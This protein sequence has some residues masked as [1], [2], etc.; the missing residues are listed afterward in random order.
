VSL[1]V[2]VV[3]EDHTL[4]QFVAIPVIAALLV[5]VGKPNAK[6]AAVTNPRVRGFENLIQHACPI[7][8]RYGAI[9]DVV[10]FIVD[11]DCGGKSGG[12]RTKAERLQRKLSSCDVYPDKAIVV[13]AVNEIEVWALWGMRREL[14]RR[15]SDVRAECHPKEIYFDPLLLAGDRFTPD[16]GRKRLISLSLREGWDS[17]KQGCPE[18]SR[19]E[20]AMRRLLQ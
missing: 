20:E 4:D 14:S 11:L 9:S 12:R 18:L 7:L 19:L 13:G 2:A 15:W 3:C 8:G 17:L 10:I 1:K 5:A 6:V 16:K